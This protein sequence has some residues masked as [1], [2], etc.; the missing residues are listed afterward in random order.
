[1]TST[2]LIRTLEITQTCVMSITVAVSNPPRSIVQV[3]TYSQE[4]MTTTRTEVKVPFI[5]MDLVGR[6]M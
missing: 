1:M 4:M 5:V 2:V 3:K 6:M